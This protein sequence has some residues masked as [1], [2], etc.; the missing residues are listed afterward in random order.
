MGFMAGTCSATFIHKK[1]VNSK[2]AYASKTI[3][4]HKKNL[5]W[6]LNQISKAQ[7]NC[8]FDVG[9]FIQKRAALNAKNFDFKTEILPFS[10]PKKKA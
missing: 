8:A 3:P 10:Q 1:S 9:W 6:F 7:S 5:R 2:Y 4:L